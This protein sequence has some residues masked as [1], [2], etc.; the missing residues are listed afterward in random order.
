MS[1]SPAPNLD[2]AVDADARPD[3]L[4][5]ARLRRRALWTWILS[6]AF[7]GVL[8]WIASQRIQLLP[9]R[10]E[11]ARLDLLL[12]G[13][14]LYLPY[15]A[16]RALRLR[17]ALDPVIARASAGS[18]TRVPPALLYGSGW[19]SFFVILLL[20][21]RLGE[22]SRPVL[23]ARPGVPGLG[24]A[25]S[26]SAVATERAVD[27]LLVVGLL[28]IGLMGADISGASLP[29][30]A[31]RVADIQA[32]GRFMAVVFALALAALVFAARAPQLVARWLETLG[33]APLLRR[34][35]VERVS[36]IV[37]RLAAA[38]RPLGSRR[39]GVPF[40]LWS[41]AYWAITVAQLWLI[42]RA[43]GLMLGL[44]EAAAI[45]AVVG[46][47]I[48]LPGG[49]AQAGS[50]QVGTALGL[51]LFVDEA[52]LAGPGSSFAAI[53]YL[54]GLVG[55]AV[56]AAWGAGLLARTPAAAARPQT[57]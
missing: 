43:C 55:A 56:F 27:G 21:L 17:Y 22:V 23:L 47:S 44:A 52:A 36:A 8:L 2:L 7:G 42:L 16:I 57:P 28:F 14:A 50:F 33:R 45:V 39:H 49:P 53:M 12:F 34:L 29:G 40:L 6:L 38:I 32:F 51:G 31:G 3:V 48:Q 11:V 19:V 10:V 54:L 46:L 9:D 13:I 4:R 41:L 30:V 15:A 35:P 37:E 26:L 1:G 24:L 25:E 18:L 5:G 20:P